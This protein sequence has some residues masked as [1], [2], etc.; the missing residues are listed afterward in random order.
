MSCA[1]LHHNV[2]INVNFLYRLPVS[3]INRA[4]NLTFPLQNVLTSASLEIIP[5]K[6][7][8]SSN[9]LKLFFLNRVNS[10]LVKDL[11]VLK[12]IE[13]LAAPVS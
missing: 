4:E 11:I 3:T 5:S 12:G 2:D 8:I 10:R 1:H 6:P 9:D 13:Q 7:S